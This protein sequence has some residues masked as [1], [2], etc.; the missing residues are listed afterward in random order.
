M[1]K[2]LIK[3]SH[4]LIDFLCG[5]EMELFGYKRDYLFTDLVSSEVLIEKKY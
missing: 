1:E 3:N 4:Q 2:T 5:P